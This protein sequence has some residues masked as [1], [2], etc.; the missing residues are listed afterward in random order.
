MIVPSYTD[1]RILHELM[2][3]WP[4]VKNKAK[5][6]GAI[7]M[8]RMPKSRI[9]LDGGLAEGNTTLHKSK[10]G[11]KW[12]VTA[13]CPHGSKTWWSVCYCEVENDH[14]TKSYYYLRGMNTPKQYYVHVIPHAIKRL[15]ERWIT[16]DRE[17]FLADKSTQEIMDW[18]VFDRHECGIF[19]KAGKVRNGVFQ[20]F[21]DGDGNTPGIVIVKGGYFYA[22]R[23]PMGNFIFKTY[24]VSK[25]EPG[26]L[27]DEFRNM[28]CALWASHN[29]PK[30]HDSTK[31]SVELM[32]KAMTFAPRMTKHMDHYLEKVVPLYP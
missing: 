13:Y 25:P 18:A 4:G 1:E 15:R 7:L 29:M 8:A 24:I 6:L 21:T 16:V 9:G 22:R 28:L 32:V 31:E 30:G 19:F 11:N 23:T 17:Q 3:D 12:R 26:S 2:D 27:K 10:N 14:G 20:E 5:K